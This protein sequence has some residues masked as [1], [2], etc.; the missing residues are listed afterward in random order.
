GAA[1]GRCPPGR[2][3][4]STSV[5]LPPDGV[6]PPPAGALRP[7]DNPGAPTPIRLPIGIRDGPAGDV[8]PP[9]SPGDAP[10][11]WGIPGLRDHR[12][13]AL[14]PAVHR[15]DHPAVAVAP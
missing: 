11:A 1:V 12:A 6:H 4:C 14:R 9:N 2:R 5:F 13:R 15:G 3:A 10:R 7:S 8:L